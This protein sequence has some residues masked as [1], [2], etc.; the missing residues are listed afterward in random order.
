MVAGEAVQC[1][2]KWLVERGEYEELYEEVFLSDSVFTAV[3]RG[4]RLLKYRALAA[5]VPCGKATSVGNCVNNVLDFMSTHHYWEVNGIDSFVHSSILSKKAMGMVTRGIVAEYDLPVRRHPWHPR[6]ASPLFRSVALNEVRALAA[7]NTQFLQ[8][9]VAAQAPALRRS[10]DLPVPMA[11]LH[12]RPAVSINQWMDIAHTPQHAVTWPSTN[13]YPQVEYWMPVD[14]IRP[15][16][17]FPLDRR[18]NA[19]ANLCSV[20]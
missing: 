1:L 4:L 2:K 3:E 5:G 16:G 8:L 6:H 19:R 18:S 12:A 13:D 17:W 14:L 11:L 15:S 9:A 7:V 10:F 20:M